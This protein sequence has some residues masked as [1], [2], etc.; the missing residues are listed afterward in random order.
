MVLLKKKK[1]MLHDSIP[2]ASK[3]P[4]SIYVTITTACLA[5][6]APGYCLLENLEQVHYDIDD[7][8]LVVYP[9]LIITQ[10]FLLTSVYL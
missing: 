7:I 6:M 9:K 10:S 1:R 5:P 2:I 3:Y 8:I 4:F